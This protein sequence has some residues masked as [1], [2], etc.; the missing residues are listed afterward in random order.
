[1]KKNIHPRGES[2]TEDTE[3]T[4]VYLQ[5]TLEYPRVIDGEGLLHPLLFKIVHF[6]KNSKKL[7]HLHINSWIGIMV[8]SGLAPLT[9]HKQQRFS[10]WEVLPCN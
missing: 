4:C 3:V 6:V 2:E 1:M 9:Y 5:M 8:L 7:S 10:T